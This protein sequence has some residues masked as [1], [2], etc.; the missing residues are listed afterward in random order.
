MWTQKGHSLALARAFPTMCASGSWLSG[1]FCPHKRNALYWVSPGFGVMHVPLPIVR[2]NPIS[3]VALGRPLNPSELHSVKQVSTP[4]YWLG[5]IWWVSRWI[6]LG[7]SPGFSFCCCPQ[8]LCSLCSSLFLPLQI[9]SSFS[10]LPYG[11][12]R[13]RQLAEALSPPPSL[14]PLLVIHCFKISFVLFFDFS[15]LSIYLIHLIMSFPKASALSMYLFQSY[16][17]QCNLHTMK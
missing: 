13:A 11:L 8:C 1:K 16:I 5:L 4:P 15:H 17:L 3:S 7:R 2:S 6:D 14:G 10:I 9:S 12:A